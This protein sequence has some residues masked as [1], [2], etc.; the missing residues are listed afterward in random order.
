MGKYWIIEF[1]NRSIHDN[2]GKQIFGSFPNGTT[3]INSPLWFSRKTNKWVCWTDSNN[4]DSAQFMRSMDGVISVKPTDIM[5]EVKW[6]KDAKTYDK[7]CF[8]I[9]KKYFD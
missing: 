7:K 8:E 6:T 1:D 2:P 4:N 5:T 3:F 9:F